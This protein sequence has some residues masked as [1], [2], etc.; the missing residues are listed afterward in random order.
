MTEDFYPRE[1]ARAEF[2][3]LCP[4]YNIYEKGQKRPVRDGKPFD[5]MV[6]AHERLEWIQRDFPEFKGMLEVRLVEE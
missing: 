1:K 5:T 3:R 2:L 6:A 4:L